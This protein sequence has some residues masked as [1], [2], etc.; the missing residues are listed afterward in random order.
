MDN[1]EIYNEAPKYFHQYFDLVETDD[2][3]DELIKTKKLIIEFLSRIPEQK[4]KFK[5]APEK[6]TVEEVIRH[7]NDTERIFAYRALR[8]SRGDKKELL[9]FDENKYV[10]STK[11]MDQTLKELINE[12][13]T[14][15][16]S[17]IL[18][19]LSMTEEML[20]RKGI[21]NQTQISTR[22]IGFMMIGHYQHHCNIL[23]E[24]YL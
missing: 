4:L 15:R 23:R 7:C 3:V 1:Q 9:G 8:F 2:L 14:I 21:S 11:Q 16:E 20:K 18:L 13:A 5:Y 6:W 10:E 17:N 12:F 19:F 22:A 24:R